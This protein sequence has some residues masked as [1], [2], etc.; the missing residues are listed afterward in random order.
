M[1]V[2][3][4][5][6]SRKM[7]VNTLL[8]GLIYTEENVDSLDKLLLNLFEVNTKANCK[9]VV[10]LLPI[11]FKLIGRYISFATYNSIVIPV[12]EGKLAMAAE[13]YLPG[14]AIALPYILEGYVEVQPPVSDT[15]FMVEI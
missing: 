15:D 14:A 3:P 1:K 6:E 2:H 11:I 7:A 4:L 13:K 10:A 9:H 8:C 5:L 12:L